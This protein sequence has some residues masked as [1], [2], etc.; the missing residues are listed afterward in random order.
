[1][2][3]NSLFS[4]SDT[5][6]GLNWEHIRLSYVVPLYINKPNAAEVLSIFDE[7]AKYPADILDRVLF[8]LVD[9]GSPAEFELP[10]WLL[11]M[12]VLRIKQDIPWNNP[13]ARNL[14]MVYAK[15]DKVFLT[16][17]DHQLDVRSFQALMKMG[18]PGRMLCVASANVRNSPGGR[19]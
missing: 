7:Y 11:N 15:S 10:H 9:D 16:D 3:K 13:G 18:N 4:Y 14:G 17:I 8:V 19:W 12:I 2:P 6:K 5:L 1:M